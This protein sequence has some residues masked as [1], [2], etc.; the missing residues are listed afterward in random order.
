MD[1]R[2]IIL[3]I[4]FSLFVII[5]GFFLWRVFFGSRTTP[6]TTIPGDTTTTPGTSF[7]GAGDSGDRVTIDD[8]PPTLPTAPRVPSGNITGFERIRDITTARVSATDLSSSG[9]LRY[10]NKND[11]KF[12]KV[13]ADGSV[14]ELSDTVFFQ[15]DNVTWS[16]VDDQAIIEYPD[17]SNIYYNF[18]TQEQVTLPQHWE[19]FSFAPQ[20]DQIAAKSVTLAPEN[21][22]L[23]TSNPNGQNV[24][25]VEPMGENQDEV[26]VDWSPT[27]Q[28]LAFSTTGRSLGA[29]RQEVLM[30]GQYGENFKSLVVE[31]RGF[32]GSWSTEGTKLV[33][34]VYSARNDFKP[35]LWVVDASGDSIGANRQ[36]L[37]VN[38]WAS[39]C[40][41]QNDRYVYCGVPTTLDTGAGFAPQIANN[42]PDRIVRIDTVSGVQTEISTGGNTYTV[43]SIR[44]SEDGSRLY[45]TDSQSSRLSEII[46]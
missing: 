38:T 7:P 11:G 10:Y 27:K 46:L 4:L 32:Q 15:A 42:T 39:K 31:G 3:L 28:V 8:T 36:P 26:T 29:D 17:G 18:E 1:R 13:N 24:R 44:V 2:R 12:Y 9:N 20:A 30:I 19:D 45:I 14:T 16:N 5:L 21:R 41:F 34:S 23:I 6:P 25:L 35:E 37:S 22:W 33:Y 43:E 40:D